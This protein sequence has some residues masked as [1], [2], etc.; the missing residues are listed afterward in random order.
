MSTVELKVPRIRFHE[1]TDPWEQRKLDE[2][3]ERV[4]RKNKDLESELP[5]TISAQYGLVDQESFFNKRIAAKDI[6]NYFL[7]KN[8]EF[9]YNKSYSVGY[10]FGAVKRLDKYDK[11]VLS[12]LYIVFNPKSESIDS[13]FLTHYFE[14]DRWYKHVSENAAEGARNHGLLNITAS[15]FLKLPLTVPTNIEEQRKIAQ[16]LGSVDESIALHRRNF[17]VH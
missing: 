3:T 16:F 5:L 14:T 15:D 12:S 8:G 6:T 13:D 17:V 11:G 7:I 9:A 4:T 1:F 10:P 2:I